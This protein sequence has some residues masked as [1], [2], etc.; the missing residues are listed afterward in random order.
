MRKK[1]FINKVYNRNSDIMAAPRTKAERNVYYIEE[2]Y[3]E[4]ISKRMNEKLKLYDDSKIINILPYEKIFNF[5]TKTRNY[6]LAFNGLRARKLKIVLFDRKVEPSI[7]K[8][9][10]EIKFTDKDQICYCIEQDYEK[11]L[12]ES[13]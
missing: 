2:E 8:Q 5:E 9:I 12:E 11:T 6:T 13:L 4:S 1:E 7:P 3:G 10:G